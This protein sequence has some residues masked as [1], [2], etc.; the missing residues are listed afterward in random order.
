MCRLSA[1]SKG[2]KNTSNLSETSRAGK[3]QLGKKSNK[4]EG[5]RPGMACSKS[6]I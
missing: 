4:L 2:R 3:V 6:Q 1:L 5:T